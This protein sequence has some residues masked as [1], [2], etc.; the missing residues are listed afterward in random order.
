MTRFLKYSAIAL[1]AFLTFVP[2]ASARGSLS[3]GDIWAGAT[4]AVASVLGFYPG[5]YY[6]YGPWY[7]PGYYRLADG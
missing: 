4:M 2:A 6:G 3:A 1:L 5:G 7:G